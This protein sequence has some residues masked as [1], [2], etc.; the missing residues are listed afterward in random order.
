MTKKL[1]IFVY[2]YLIGIEH[3]TKIGAVGLIHIIPVC[4][5]CGFIKQFFS[6]T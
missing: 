1:E 3:Y 6:I 4:E 2:L 5:Y